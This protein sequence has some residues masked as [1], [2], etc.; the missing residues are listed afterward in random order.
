LLELKTLAASAEAAYAHMDASY[1][2]LSAAARKRKVPPPPSALEEKKSK[3]VE[4][5]ASVNGLDMESYTAPS[6]AQVLAS[7]D[8]GS[9][10][11]AALADDGDAA[12]S[13]GE[14]DKKADD[15]SGGAKEVEDDED[16]VV[17]EVLAFHATADAYC[18]AF[19]ALALDFV[20]RKQKEVPEGG[21]EVGLA[22]YISMSLDPRTPFK[23]NPN[24]TYTNGFYK[25]M[26]APSSQAFISIGFCMGKAV[27]T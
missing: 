4:K 25:T 26:R 24:L 15:I 7:I 8:G 11:G 13:V 17:A 19:R 22:Y 21:G 20:G 9:D 14:R 23:E 2:Q 6:A 27:R 16:P 12:K 18:A 5:E 3:E 1:K 10:G